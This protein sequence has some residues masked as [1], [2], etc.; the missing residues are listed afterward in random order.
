M[1]GGEPLGGV[2]VVRAEDL[3]AALESGRTAARAT[4]LPVEARPFQEEPEG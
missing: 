3:D 2:I 4:A 1:K